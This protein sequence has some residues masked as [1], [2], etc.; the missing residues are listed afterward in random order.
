VAIAVLTVV[1]LAGLYFLGDRLTPRDAAGRPLI[2]S[3]SVR[4]AES[5]RR[6]IK[7]WIDQ[8]AWLDRRLA[9]LLGADEI[10][11][12]AQLYALSDEAESL[13]SQATGLAE[14]V[15]FTP[16]PPALM[17]LSALAEESATVHLEAALAVS[18]W[19]GAPDVD[20]LRAALEAL[21]AARSHRRALEESQWVR[22]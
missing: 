6:R 22:E 9:A 17:G 21:R 5:Y 13:L 19:I 4:A 8:M 15:A 11:D 14:D 16:A 2:Y 20:Q 18:Q 10:T 7:G 3:P 1:A 12:A